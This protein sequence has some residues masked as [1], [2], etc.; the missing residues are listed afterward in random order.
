[1]TSLIVYSGRTS[2]TLSWLRSEWPCLG[3]LDAQL[4]PGNTTETGECLDAANVDVV[5]VRMVVTFK[6]LRPCYQYKVS[7]SSVPFAIVVEEVVG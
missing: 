6:N 3:E 1:M 4:C 5:N 7:T 2:A